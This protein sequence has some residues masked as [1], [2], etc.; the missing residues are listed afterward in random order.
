M[1][2]A[3]VRTVCYDCYDCYGGD[4]VGARG[5]HGVGRN[6]RLMVLGNLAK[7]CFLMLLPLLLHESA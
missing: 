1:I 3:A 2:L 6:D 7:M 5:R 4:G